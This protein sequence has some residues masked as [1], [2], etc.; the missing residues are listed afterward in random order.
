MCLEVGQTGAA[1]QT[2]DPAVVSK[3]AGSRV[4]FGR[5]FEWQCR[6]PPPI[7][8][9]PALHRQSGGRRDRHDKRDGIFMAKAVL[10]IIGGSG[11]YDLPGLTNAQTG[12]WPLSCRE[13]KTIGRPAISPVNSTPDGLP[14]RRRATFN[15]RVNIDVLKRAGVTGS[16]FAFRL[17]FI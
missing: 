4:R 16:R 12:R 9:E 13:R 10:G 7:C 17:R 11:I 8:R 5:P 2:V 3:T 15:Y 14:G 1:R 6:S